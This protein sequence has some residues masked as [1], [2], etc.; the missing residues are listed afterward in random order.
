MRSLALVT[1]LV[2]GLL[3]TAFVG[4]MYW[5]IAGI[6]DKPDSIWPLVK[7]W[8]PLLAGPICL[9]I[10]TLLLLRGH[11]SVAPWLI[12][13]ACAGLTVFALYESFV[14]LQPAPLQAEPPYVL[15]AT[16]L[17]IVAV[18]DIAAWIAIQGSMSK[19]WTAPLK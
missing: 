18:A 2:I 9:I 6:A 5:S 4:W 11:S 16:I 1:L 3:A 15:F 19:T 8:M 14:G 17:V 7:F 12:G 13:L 10:G